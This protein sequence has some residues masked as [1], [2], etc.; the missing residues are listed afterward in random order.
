MSDGAA[1]KI[2]CPWPTGK[3]ITQQE[4][5]FVVFLSCEL[6]TQ[7]GNINLMDSLL[8]IIKG[9]SGLEELF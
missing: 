4:L 9:L 1:S 3:E 8:Q 5:L 7:R 6:K 2:I